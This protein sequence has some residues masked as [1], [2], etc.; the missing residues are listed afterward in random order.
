MKQ[1][2]VEKAVMTYHAKTELTNADIMELFDVKKTKAQQ[3]KKIVLDE[4]A[5]RGVKCFMSRSINTEVAYEVWK[6]D[7]NDLEKR[8]NKLRSLKL[9]EGG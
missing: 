9:M 7:I 2:D 1:P 3:M 4:M 8:L 6:L 5:K